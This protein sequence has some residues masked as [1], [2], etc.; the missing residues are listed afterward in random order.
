VKNSGQWTDVEIVSCNVADH[1]FIMKWSCLKLHRDQATVARKNEEVN[2]DYFCSSAF[3]HFS[4]ILIVVT[5][6]LYWDIL[7]LTVLTLKIRNVIR[8]K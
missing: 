2:G 1:E 7:T 3:Q 8:T 5:F 6:S 4:L